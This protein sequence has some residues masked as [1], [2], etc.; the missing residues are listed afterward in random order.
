MSEMQMSGCV[1]LVWR[2]VVLS[3]IAALIGCGG[4]VVTRRVVGERKQPR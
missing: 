4:M 1:K 2:A 3:W